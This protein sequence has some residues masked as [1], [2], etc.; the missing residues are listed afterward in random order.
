M[1][2]GEGIS[3]RA[4]L[5]V[6]GSRACLEKCLFFGRKKGGGGGWVG[7]RGDHLEEGEGHGNEEGMADPR[8]FDLGDSEHSV[9][10]ITAGIWDI[11]LVL[12]CLVSFYCEKK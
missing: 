10:D 8:L 7:A 1:Y 3:T 2:V 9:P 5:S 12:Q 4:A 6:M 11:L